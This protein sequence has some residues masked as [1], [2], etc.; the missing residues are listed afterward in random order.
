MKKILTIAVAFVLVLS[1]GACK[2][3]GFENVD[4]ISYGTSFGMCAGYCHNELSISGNKTTMTRQQNGNPTATKKC[5]SSV[6]ESEV[7][8]IKKLLN[9]NAVYKL[10]KVIG[11]PDCADGGAEWVKIK[12]NGKEYEIAFEYGH[13]PEAL[14]VAV[15]KLKAIS[16]T[17]KD[18]K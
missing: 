2:K 5:N 18:C 14:K 3:K 17:F 4:S 16:E 8:E 15:D 13:A 6:S 12:S 7:N 1:L 10:P 11:C 9:T